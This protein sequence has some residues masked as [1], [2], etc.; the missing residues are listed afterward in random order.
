MNQIKSRLVLTAIFLVVLLAACST[1]S[2]SDRIAEV[3]KKGE[4]VMP[5]DLERS[6]HIFRK[7]ADGGLQQVV[8]D[9]GDADQIAEIRAHLE[10]EAGR[11]Q[12]GDFHDPAMIHGDDMAGL[13][14]LVQGADQL[15][16]VYSEIENGGQIVYSAEIPELVEALHLWF[17]QQL[18]DHGSHAQS[19]QW[20]DRL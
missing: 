14:E 15:S 4:S 6:T 12:N 1:Q 18:S 16:I 19:D 11:F 7:Q 10:E 9:D 20:C 13:H 2:H 3:A 8:S 5:F 17:D